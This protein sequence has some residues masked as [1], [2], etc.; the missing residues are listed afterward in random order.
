MAG[1]PRFAHLHNHTTYSLLDGAQRL[2]EMCRRAVEDGQPALAITDHGNLFGVMEFSKQA[3]KAGVKPIV[4][5]EAYIAP[6]SRH[7]RTPRTRGGAKPYNHLILL[8][9]NYTGYKNL[10][11]LSS[12]GYLEGF[13]Y[14]PR[15]DKELLEQ[16]SEGLVCLSACLAGEIPQHLM[17]ARMKEA[18]ESAAWFRDLFG[19][20]RYWLELQDHGI[21]EQ[22][23]VNEGIMNI[24]SELK[25]PTVATND[26]HYLLHDD[27]FAHDVL[28]CIQT[29]KTVN[30]A[31]RMQYSR[32]HYL[33]S[34]AEMSDLFSWTPESVENSVRVADL[35]NFEFQP[36]GNHLPD[37]PVP[38]GLTLDEYLRK[39]ALEGLEKRL[40]RVRADAD[41]GRATRT[42]AEY[43]ER[44]DRELKIICDMGFPGYFLIVWDFIRFAREQGIPVG[45][46]RGSAAGSLVAYSMQITD[47][48][49]MTYDLLFERFLNPERVS[50]PDIDIDFCCRRREDVI[51]YVTEKYGRPNVAQVITFGTMAARAVIRDVGRGLEVPY[52]EV[53]KIAK[54][55]PVQ[56]GQDVTIEQSIQEVPALKQ[57]YEDD[58]SI[59]KMLDVAQRL[60][61]LTRHAS[62]HAAAVV[63]APKAI[64]EYAPLYKGNKDSDEITTQ[65]AKDEIEE[66]GL[67]KMD[68]LGLKTLTIIDD[69]LQSIEASGQPR[70]QLETLPLDDPE[71][72]RLFS[73]ARTGGLFQFASDGMRDILRRLKPDAFE[74]L[75]ALY[76]LLCPGPI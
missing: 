59:S 46:G 28:V 43:R 56:P 1:S 14:R 30:D 69:A 53:D 13:Y 52:A 4:G 61:G 41:A 70:P 57:A 38:E 36:S 58:E 49:P 33:K 5:I 32:Q 64:T 35:C 65:F 3:T 2:D 40:Q 22:R 39:V 15:I 48:D 72:F 66:I 31:S 51:D 21:P 76:P 8:A 26:C 63:I 12:K 7:D 37:F 55:I 34:Q 24:A 75:I 45:P 67:L 27:H 10:I 73:E 25:L 68:F 50:L 11:Q 17:N 60:E 42:E 62:T 9:Q 23:L 16:H 47:I 44:L 6:G 20:D 29:G 19:E 71:V 74:A 18:R 54:M